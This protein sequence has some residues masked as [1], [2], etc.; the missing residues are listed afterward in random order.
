M[1]LFFL[2][3]AS[4][5]LFSTAPLHGQE[6]SLEQ[7]VASIRS[8]HQVKQS[9]ITALNAECATGNCENNNATEIC[10]LVGAL[11]VRTGNLI[12]TMDKNH[13]AKP[14]IAISISDIQLFKRIWK[15]CRPSSYQYWNYGTI[16][17]VVY[18]FDPNEDA[19]IR[20]L[21][22]LYRHSS[23]TADQRTFSNDSS[24]V[25]DKKLTQCLISKARYGQYS[26]YDGG[27]SARV[28]LEQA[29]PVE[30]VGWIESCEKNADTRNS[31]VM[32]ASILA[33][34]AIKL[35]NK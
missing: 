19:E 18:E 2:A 3:A 32:K 9:I 22:G 23:K 31:C 1:K 14:E 21:L 17:H 8:V 35:L 16:L 29:C 24:L 5:T 34:T 27:K 13:I 25:A 10:S 28:L 30:Y 7:Y 26:S 11:D 4:I 33:Q 20:K 6:S 12:T 15:Q